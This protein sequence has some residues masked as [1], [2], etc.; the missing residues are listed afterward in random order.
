MIEPS[1]SSLLK[2]VDNI[3]TLCIITGK[4]ARQLTNGAQKLTGC[5]SQKAVTIAANEIN[6]NM[7][8][9]VRKKKETEIIGENK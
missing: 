6:E 4:R 3:Y 2:K 5:N 1:L 7:I 8:T 9:Y